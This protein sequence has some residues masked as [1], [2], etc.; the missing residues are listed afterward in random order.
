MLARHLKSIR[1]IASSIKVLNNY[2]KPNV[3]INAVAK[4]L[5]NGKLSMSADIFYCRNF[6]MSFLFTK[7]CFGTARQPDKDAG[8]SKESLRLA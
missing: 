6:C 2:E 3:R 8:W 7:E 1:N 4:R 5:W